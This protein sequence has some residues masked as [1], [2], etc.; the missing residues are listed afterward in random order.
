MFSCLLDPSC[1]EFNVISLS[2]FSVIWAELLMISA[3]NC[4][5]RSPVYEYQRVEF[6]STFPVRTECD[7][8]VM[9]CIQCCMF[10]STVL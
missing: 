2:V 5:L 1:G 7:M 9:C 10:V 3:I 8:F 4:P 6:S